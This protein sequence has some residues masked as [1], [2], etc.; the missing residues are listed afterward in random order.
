MWKFLADVAQSVAAATVCED[1]LGKD[2]GDTGGGYESDESFATAAS[3]DTLGTEATVSRSSPPAKHRALSLLPAHDSTASRRLGKGACPLCSVDVF[4]SGPCRNCTHRLALAEAKYRAISRRTTNTLNASHNASQPAT[5]RNLLDE[6][7]RGGSLSDILS[8]VAWTK[9]AELRESHAQVSHE[10]SHS[11]LSPS[12]QKNGNK[13]VSRR[14]A[15]SLECKD[16]RTS[17]NAPLKNVQSRKTTVGPAWQSSFGRTHSTKPQGETKESRAD[18]QSSEFR[19]HGRYPSRYAS[20]RLDSEE[21]FPVLASNARSWSRDRKPRVSSCSRV[22]VR[23]STLRVSTGNT[24]MLTDSLSVL[25]VSSEGGSS[26]CRSVSETCIPQHMLESEG[27]DSVVE[28][29]IVSQSSFLARVSAARRITISDII[30]RR[31]KLKKEAQRQS[32]GR[33][34]AQ[35]VRSHSSRRT[36]SP[37]GLCTRACRSRTLPCNPTKS[38]RFTRL[39]PPAV[40]LHMDSIERE[41]TP[42]LLV[43][44]PSINGRRARPAAHAARPQRLGNR[45]SPAKHTNQ[46]PP[47]FIAAPFPTPAESALAGHCSLEAS[48]R[49]ALEVLDELRHPTAARI[50]EPNTIQLPRGV[51]TTIDPAQPCVSDAADERV[52]NQRRSTCGNDNAEKRPADEESNILPTAHDVQ[53]RVDSSTEAVGTSAGNTS[54]PAQAPRRR[55]LHGRSTNDEPVPTQAAHS[56]NALPEAVGQALHCLRRS[57][58]VV[59]SSIAPESEIEDKRPVE[60]TFTVNNNYYN[61]MTTDSLG[62]SPAKNAAASTVDQ[63][64]EGGK[65]PT[66][67]TAT[68]ATTTTTTPVAASPTTS[69]STLEYSPSPLGAREPS[70]LPFSAPLLTTAEQT[71]A[72]SRQRAN[73]A[74]ESTGTPPGLRDGASVP[75][76]DSKDALGICTF[77]SDAIGQWQNGQVEMAVQLAAA[78][79]PTSATQPTLGNGAGS[80]GIPEPGNM[81]SIASNPPAHLA[82]LAETP[83]NLRDARGLSATYR[84]ASAVQPHSRKPSNSRRTTRSPSTVGHGPRSLGE[85][86]LGSVLDASVNRPPPAPHPT[87]VAS[88]PGSP[89]RLSCV[90][91]RTKRKNRARSHSAPVSVD[92]AKSIKRIERFGSR[93]GPSSLPHTPQH[94]QHETQ[95]D[96]DYFDPDVPFATQ[97]TLSS[98]CQFSRSC[99]SESQESTHCYTCKSADPACHLPRDT[100]ATSLFRTGDTHSSVCSHL[101]STSSASAASES[102]S[103]PMAA[104][105]CESRGVLLFTGESSGLQQTEQTAPAT[106]RSR[107]SCLSSANTRYLASCQESSNEQYVSC[108][109]GANELS[110][111]SNDRANATRPSDTRGIS[112]SIKSCCSH[113]ALLQSMQRSPVYPP[114]PR[115]SSESWSN[116]AKAWL[117]LAECEDSDEADNR[118]SPGCMKS[119]RS[120]SQWGLTG[121]T[122][123]TA[124]DSDDEELDIEFLLANRPTVGNTADPRFRPVSELDRRSRGLDMHVDRASEKK[125]SNACHKKPRIHD[126]IG[127]SQTQRHCVT[128]T[129]GPQQRND[130]HMRHGRKHALLCGCCTNGSY[131]DPPTTCSCGALQEGVQ[132]CRR[133]AH[134][135][136]QIAHDELVGVEQPG[137]S[138]REAMNSVVLEGADCVRSALSKTGRHGARVAPRSAGCAGGPRCEI[139]P[140]LFAPSCDRSGRNHQQ[141]H[142]C[143]DPLPPAESGE[144]ARIELSASNRSHI[145]DPP[146][147]NNR[148]NRRVALPEEPRRRIAITL[149]PPTT[150]R[151]KA[152][153]RHETVKSSFGSPR[154]SASLRARSDRGPEK[155]PDTGTLAEGATQQ[156]SRSSIDVVPMAALAGRQLRPAFTISSSAACD[157][158][159]GKGADE[160]VS[161]ALKPVFARIP[162]AVQAEQQPK[163][164]DHREAPSKIGG[165]LGQTE[166]S[167]ESGALPR[168]SLQ[169]ARLSPPPPAKCSEPGSE[170]IFSA[171]GEA[172]HPPGTIAYR[173]QGFP[174]QPHFPPHAHI[175]NTPVSR[176]FQPLEMESQ[177]RFSRLQSPQSWQNNCPVPF[178]PLQAGQAFHTVDTS[179]PPRPVHSSEQMQPSSLRAGSSGYLPQAS[180]LSHQHTRTSSAQVVE[181]T[182]LAEK[183][184]AV[185]RSYTSVP[186]PVR[187]TVSS[188]RPIEEACSRVNKLLMM[189]QESD[190]KRIL[191]PTKAEH[192]LAPR[193]REM[194]PASYDP[195]L[196]QDP[197]PEHYYHRALD[198]PTT[199]QQAN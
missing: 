51:S 137:P 154:S 106:S 67:I 140:A 19:L 174:D 127:I 169:P 86:K 164:D 92:L 94:D 135:D 81:P 54:G 13:R 22:G 8:I 44:S 198:A 30:A 120:H 32:L 9:S 80:T 115:P 63:E 131:E 83:S 163:T 152:F 181:A 153:T 58:A 50:E 160:T 182:R 103:K 40:R 189:T 180:S 193:S 56:S 43:L 116:D 190:T 108:F 11:M 155:Y 176:R 119:C 98:N 99:A 27:T 139:T 10:G 5:H 123:S 49:S 128:K 177:L 23:P 195:F 96:C 111:G 178:C 66:I 62:G 159:S 77:S 144:A 188:Q 25:E 141:P 75:R 24:G 87:V 36:A 187:Q 167:G 156:P 68:S 73:G 113:P 171:R 76:H 102:E 151:E 16:D 20:G 29:T 79:S 162:P 1:R 82:T 114:T 97:N 199:S 12:S 146:V 42:L 88:A 196:L 21:R 124:L 45:Q 64:L 197:F 100:V 34:F 186:H 31:K 110:R 161:T 138:K 184:V 191:L 90:C 130:D 121:T 46:S 15:A 185:A 18:G 122:H 179:L 61:S 60:V 84:T 165:P 168:V 17:H 117:P 125:P 157:G 7:L 93:T 57:A 158:N 59:A 105:L 107:S 41:G 69:P 48:I 85:N 129:Q 183:F 170:E 72:G 95:S 126:E 104:K 33:F 37:A 52:D 173:S 172:V 89:L 175:H 132:R 150:N 2:E 109:V 148:R 133:R 39:S 74:H 35:R 149:V 4:F 118:S 134:Q 70:R 101:Q 14:M 28:D 55:S 47:A 194:K 143:E 6:S 192:P 145:S 71:R 147:D 136:L 142:S 65:R 26:S 91:K 3:L 38:S 112:V 53:L 78:V 166:A